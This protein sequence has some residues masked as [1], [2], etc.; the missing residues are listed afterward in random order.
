MRRLPLLVIV[1]F[2][3]AT[4]DARAQPAGGEAALAGAW[5]VTYVHGETICYVAPQPIP[6]PP[7]PPD[8]ATIRIVEP[9]TIAVELTEGTTMMYRVP[10]EAWIRRCSVGERV[11]PQ[12]DEMYENPDGEGFQYASTITE[13]AFPIN[14]LLTVWDPGPVHGSAT[15]DIWGGAHG[16]ITYRT[17]RVVRPGASASD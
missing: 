5:H 4:T 15:L 12:N 1:S 13:T 3:G 8:R 17:A 6:V 9:G 16:C 11:C 14:F 10:A 2:V 7:S